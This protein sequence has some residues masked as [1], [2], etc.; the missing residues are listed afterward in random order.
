MKLDN[1]ERMLLLGLV[2]EQI[3]V[4]ETEGNPTHQWDGKSYKKPRRKYGLAKMTTLYELET[5]L[6]QE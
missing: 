3:R 1:K 4:G 2:R 5:K 6:K